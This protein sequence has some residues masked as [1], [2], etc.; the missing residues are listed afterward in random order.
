MKTSLVIVCALSALA[1]M[2]GVAAG[3]ASEEGF[4]GGT[5]VAISDGDMLASTYVNGR[6]GAQESADTL[7]VATVSPDLRDLSLATVEV[8][9][10]VAGA[11]TA[12]AVTPDGRF[13]VVS[14]SFGQR[15]PDA[16]GFRDLPIGALLTLVDI[17]DTASPTVVQRLD[18]GTRPEGLSLSPAGDMV[19]VAM[20]PADGR[21]IAFVPLTD[22]RL[23]APS[24]AAVPGTEAGDRL[25]HVEWHPSG[26]F[27]AITDVNRAIVRFARVVRG[28]EGVTLEVWGNPVL[29][30]KYPFMGRFTP[31]GRHFLTGNLYW[32]SDVVGI[33]TEAPTGDVTAI[34]FAAE[35]GETGP[36]HFLVGRAGTG[37]SPEGIAISPDGQWIVTTNLEVSYAPSDDPRHTPFSSLTLIRI[38]RETGRLTT[39]GTY[40]FDGILPEAAVWDASSS[41]VAVVTYDQL[42]PQTPGGAIDFWRLVTAPSPMLVK[43]RQSLPT[44][45]GPHSMVRAN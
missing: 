43:Q 24:Y 33:W 8:S 2:P 23:G 36:R 31:D 4:Q 6:L 18:V 20:H 30:S 1:M 17:S 37:I 25:S 5:L 34:R 28:D 35:P 7:M 22:G 29:T 16:T 27:V 11:P 40:A 26:E 3:Q 9:N 42:D 32:G 10:S 44:P 21:G 13:A 41:F 12:V 38:A 45:H 15:G 39:V 14:E 19:A